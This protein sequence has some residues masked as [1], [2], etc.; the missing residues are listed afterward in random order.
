MRCTRTQHRSQKNLPSRRATFLPCYDSKTTAGGRQRSL[1]RT[2]GL[3]LCPPTTCNLVDPL[4][5]DQGRLQLC[6]YFGFSGSCIF[7]SFHDRSTCCWFWLA[8][9]VQTAISGRHSFLV[10]QCI[11]WI[12]SWD[13]LSKVTKLYIMTC[14][15]PALTL[16]IESS[17]SAHS[18]HLCIQYKRNLSLRL[19]MA[20]SSTCSTCEGRGPS[21]STSQSCILT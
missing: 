7:P 5:G 21:P 8:F 1:V 15:T 9:W 2:A 6:D 11:D 18:H 3:V 4:E 14:W 17:I 10:Y 16:L 20:S 12:V 19:S 13:R